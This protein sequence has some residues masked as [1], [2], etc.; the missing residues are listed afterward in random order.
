MMIADLRDPL[1]SK[2]EYFRTESPDRSPI[3]IER[4]VIERLRHPPAGVADERAEITP[5]VSGQRKLEPIQPPYGVDAF[6]P[7]ALTIDDYGL[8]MKTGNH[9][10]EVM[11][12]EGLEVLPDEVF[13]SGRHVSFPSRAVWSKSSMKARALAV[14]L[15]A[16]W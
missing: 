9:P 5:T 14:T 4:A 7:P 10:F 16:S 6:V 3:T 13:F 2:L 12:V 15:R 11:L 1:V 8:R